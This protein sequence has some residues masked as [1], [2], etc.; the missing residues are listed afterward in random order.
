M[1]EKETEESILRLE[2][3]RW[4]AVSM[5]IISCNYVLKSYGYMNDI[6]VSPAEKSEFKTCWSAYKG[7]GF[8]SIVCA[9]GGS[10][11]YK[12]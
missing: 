8:L 5:S 6:N 1:S 10:V 11:A 12:P 7:G 3:A 2:V 4:L 9:A